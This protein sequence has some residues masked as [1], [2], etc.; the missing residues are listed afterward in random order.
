MSNSSISSFEMSSKRFITKSVA[1]A[2]LTSC[3]V[4][5][6]N[7]ASVVAG[8]IYKDGASLVCETKRDWVRSG[9][10]K[11]DQSRASV[12]FLGNSKVL[13]GVLPDRFDAAMNQETHSWNLALP[14]LPIGPDY[15]EL[16]EYLRHNPPPKFIVLSLSLDSGERGGLFDLYAS[17]GLANPEELLSYARH[18]KD[19]TFVL[20][21]LL[22]LLRYRFY[23]MRYAFNLV[24]DR[25]NIES[26]KLRNQEIL[27]DIW[28]HRGYYWIQEQAF[29][30]GH[31]PDDYE[32]KIDS[33][34][35]SGPPASP[36]TDYFADAFFGLTAR[37][38]IQVL[39][40]EPPVPG[41]ERRMAPGIAL[42][43]FSRYGNV[44]AAATREE[45]YPNR[46]FSDPTHLSPEGARLYTAEVVRE[47]REVF[48]DHVRAESGTTIPADAHSENR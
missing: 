8:S 24:H 38:G 16:T 6:L 1:F 41:R 34:A 48:G 42:E 21:W 27:A 32:A 12:L 45:A 13:A 18:R 30:G 20:N 26:T 22:P 46:L 35:A 5:G 17:E 29:A 7:R 25:A 31:L 11:A 10:V 43:S 37:L 33:P 28:E 15:F 23:L 39:L 47:F 19:R 14:A 2:L 4:I 9:R 3:V 36:V 40:I 44:K